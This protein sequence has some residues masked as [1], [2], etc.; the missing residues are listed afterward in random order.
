[1]LVLRD[2]IVSTKDQ[3]KAAH[4]QVYRGANDFSAPPGAVEQNYVE[5]SLVLAHHQYHT[6]I[7]LMRFFSKNASQTK[8]KIKTESIPELTL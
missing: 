6:S 3:S 5:A 1:M 4:S 2:T 8:L 7:D